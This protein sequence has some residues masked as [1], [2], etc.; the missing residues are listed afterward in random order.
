L[1]LEDFPVTSTAVT[2]SGLGLVLIYS[3]SILEHE[4]EVIRGS[5]GT[6][7]VGD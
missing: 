5:N 1:E 2:M 6:L 3:K 4:T 7:L